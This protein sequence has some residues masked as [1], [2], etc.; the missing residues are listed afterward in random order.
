MYTLHC[1]D[2][3]TFLYYMV[4]SRGNTWSFISCNIGPTL[5]DIG[6]RKETNEESKGGCQGGVKGEGVFT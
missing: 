4:K 2:E 3:V 6:Q 1:T 5:V